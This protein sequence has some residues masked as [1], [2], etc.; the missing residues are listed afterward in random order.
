MKLNEA[1]GITRNPYGRDQ[2]M[3]R[4]ARLA[5]CDEVERLQ[6][7]EPLWKAQNEINAKDNETLRQCNHN[8]FEKIEELA[9]E[10]EHWQKVISKEM[11][12]KKLLYENGRL[13]LSATHPLGEA[14][15]ASLVS[16]FI[17]AGSENYFEMNAHHPMIGPFACILQRKEGKS[18]AEVAG[19]LRGQLAEA[20]ASAEKYRSALVKTGC[21]D[22]FCDESRYVCHECPVYP[23]VKKTQ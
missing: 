7:I 5:V 10:N 14:V 18:P 12:I 2:G 17:S 20:Q 11:H 19:E 3:V 15:I 13:D 4:E 8:Q 6:K 9:A 22:L 23:G 1:I 21:S 16:I